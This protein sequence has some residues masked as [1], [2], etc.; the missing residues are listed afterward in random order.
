MTTSDPLGG[1]INLFDWVEKNKADLQP[2][3]GNKMIHNSGRL[4][5]MMLAGPNQREDYHMNLGEEVFFQF[6]GDVC[7][8][9]LEHGAPRDFVVAEGELGLTPGAVPHSPQRVPN[10]L[11]FVIERFRNPEELDGL[12]YHVD[13]SC[14]TVLWERFFHCKDLGKELVPLIKEFFASE[15]YKTREPSKSMPPPPWS[16]DAIVDVPPVVAMSSLDLAGKS[17]RLVMVKEFVI[18][19]FGAGVGPITPIPIESWVWVYSG[20]AVAN[21]NVSMSRAGDTALFMDGLRSLEV[22]SGITVVLYNVAHLSPDELA[23]V[24]SIASPLLA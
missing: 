14:K 10:T 16:A 1:V 20:S 19:A 3:V 5:I 24:K 21:D 9:I 23:T 7:L 6:R 15:E 18:D 8:K 11:G 13:S 12:R 4:R 22:I 17:R 2:P